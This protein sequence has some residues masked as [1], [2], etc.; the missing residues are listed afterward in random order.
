MKATLLGTLAAIGLI[1]V[2]NA[3]PEVQQ[4]NAAPAYERVDSIVALRP[5]HSWKAID[6]DT[7]IVWATPF[8]PYL[9]ELKWPSPDLRFAQTI[10][11]TEYAGRVHSRFDSVYVRG[12]KYQIGEIYKLTR[13]EAKSL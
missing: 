8:K 12:F 7:L 4:Q 2:A 6:N 9:V 1:G 5:L 10:G 11:V 3:A 13:E